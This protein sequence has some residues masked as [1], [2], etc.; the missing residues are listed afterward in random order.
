MAS[1]DIRAGAVAWLGWP[2]TREHKNIT[3]LAYWYNITILF[4]CSFLHLTLFGRNRLKTILLRSVGSADFC[5]HCRLHKRLLAQGGKS[6]TYRY[7]S[8]L[9]QVVLGLV[10]ARFIV[11]GRAEFLLL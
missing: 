10:R 7:F 3:A 9:W 5:L 1:R 6:G 11:Y 2:L 4:F 8:G